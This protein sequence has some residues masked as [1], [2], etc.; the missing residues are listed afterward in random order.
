MLPKGEF[1]P[2][3]L[4]VAETMMFLSGEMKYLIYNDKVSF[5]FKLIFIF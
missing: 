2:F 3:E 5:I 1:F 4:H